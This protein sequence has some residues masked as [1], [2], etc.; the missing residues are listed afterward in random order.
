MLVNKVSF[1]FVYRVVNDIRE[2]PKAAKFSEFPSNEI[3]S[4]L[5]QNCFVNLYTI[6]KINYTREVLLLDADDAAIPT[7]AGGDAAKPQHT[8]V[9][10]P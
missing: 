4:I 9:L 3:G 6:Y 1:H 7:D 5:L 2:V 8:A 10:Q